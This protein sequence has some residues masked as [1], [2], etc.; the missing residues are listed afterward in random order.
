MAAAG[1]ALRVHS[2]LFHSCGC[3]KRY[4][5]NLSPG[6]DPNQTWCRMAFLTSQL[7]SEPWACLEKSKMDQWG[8]AGWLCP[9]Y[10]APKWCQAKCRLLY[11]VNHPALKDGN[12]GCEKGVGLE[13][14]IKSCLD[15]LQ[16][17][18]CQQPLDRNMEHVMCL[19]PLCWRGSAC[20]SQAMCQQSTV[21][22]PALTKEMGTAYLVEYL[23]LIPCR[24]D[25][26]VS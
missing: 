10:I 26:S 7:P 21:I 25:G 14:V 8:G 13:V 2:E 1:R 15:W 22:M 23:C 16:V 24:T 18:V 9:L 20:N 11:H 19:F 17:E 3:H 12:K 4:Q 6:A 5:P